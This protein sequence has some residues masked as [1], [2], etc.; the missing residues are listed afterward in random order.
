MSDYDDDDAVEAE[1]PEES[2]PEEA[3]DD[4]P[5]SEDDLH[6]I[7]AEAVG[8]E[9]EQ[10]EER[11]EDSR[12][13]QQADNLTRALRQERAQRRE[14]VKQLRERE[15]VEAVRSERFERL[16]SA[17]A[18]EQGIDP[19]EILYPD[20]PK[21]VP[22]PA[23]DGIGHIVGSVRELLTPLQQQVQALLA[24]EA[25]RAVEAQ[26]GELEA[27]VEN[28][29]A[30]V[31]AQV[32]D[33]DHAE[34]Y[35]IQHLYQ[36]GSAQL[37]QMHPDWD[38]DEIHERTVAGLHRVALDLKQKYARSG[39]SL[40]AAIYNRA[41]QQGYQPQQPGEPRRAPGGKRTD[42]LKRSLS[43]SGPGAGA[44]KPASPRKGSVLTRVLDRE[45]MSDDEFD[46]LTSKPGAWK[47]LAAETAGL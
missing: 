35:L 16:M 7:A 6:R 21:P 41:L 20:A 36:S 38:E 2:E 4:S 29:L 26:V 31:T 27:Y 10:E 3:E 33:Y 42:A 1:E 18:K 22:S 45:A 9:Q 37:A 8:E 14:L 17:I 44:G 32:P 13:R 11:P 34:Q 15:A 39:Q 28:D 46:E 23:E 19:K 47:K 12:F 43:Q 24:A 5:K 30:A 40:A 25:E